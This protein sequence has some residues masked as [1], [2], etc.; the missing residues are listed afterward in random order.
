MNNYYV[1]AYLRED[2]TPYYVGKGKN[3]RAVSK[4]HNVP[5]PK[6]KTRIVFLETNLTNT[7]ACAIER[8]MIRWYGRKD[9]GTG[10][11]RNLTDGGDGID[12]QIA[13]SWSK[14][15]KERGTDQ[16]RIQH[17]VATRKQTGVSVI[18][19]R[20]AAQTR[21]D[22]GDVFWTKENHSRAVA[23]RKRLGS[24]KSKPESIS[25]RTITQRNNGA[26]DR[27]AVRMR[28]I[29]Q[30]PIVIE[31]KALF[32]RFKQLMAFKKL[33]HN[34]NLEKQR[35]A[36]NTILH[37]YQYVF[38]TED[39][40]ATTIKELYALRDTLIDKIKPHKNWHVEPNLTIL[41]N[42]VIELNALISR[43]NEYTLQP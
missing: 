26:F 18:S 11:L 43:F 30:R 28:E 35:Q 41:N 19:S 33:A 9:L 5:V 27:A 29:A 6:E 32:K 17:M 39:I 20:K 23:T 21:R 25:A 12:P 8:R 4:H 42:K 7:G 40:Q 3:K 34:L 1:Y 31:T 38:Q 16:L 24:Y 36:I 13:A 2:G 15:S 37:L 14:L 10:I 22:N